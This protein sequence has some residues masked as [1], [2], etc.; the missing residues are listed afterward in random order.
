MVKRSRTSRARA[1]LALRTTV[2]CLVLGEAVTLE[3]SLVQCVQHFFTYRLAF[4]V[5]PT[6]T[7]R[8]NRRNDQNRKA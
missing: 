1:A 2:V 3:F 5:P 7:V 8:L 6:R 4:D